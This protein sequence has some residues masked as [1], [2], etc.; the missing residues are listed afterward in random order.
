MY[1][2]SGV[3]MT[4]RKYEGTELDLF[5]KAL[6]WK[7]YYA[8]RISSCIQGDVLEVGAGIGGITVLL[9]PGQA[10]SWLCVEPDSALA[11]T[12]LKTVSS[13]KRGPAPKVVVGCLEDVEADSRFDCILYI[14]VLEHIEADRA[15]MERAAALLR[16]GGRIVV[17]SPAHSFLYSEF[18]SQIGH[19]RR[20][21]RN[22]IAAACPSGVTVESCFYLDS[23]G[24]L[25]S[26]ANKLMLRSA[27]PTEAQILI[28]DRFVIPAS[29]LVDRLLGYRFGKSI[30]MVWRKP[31]STRAAS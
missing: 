27:F 28:W 19:F 29:R 20:Y 30:V 1:R 8:S 12:L 3:R 15:E 18:D 7:R 22:S 21:N 16:A 17:L 6:N 5:A 14:D 31:E 24:I 11:A 23:V 2:L 9:W 10:T 26:L 25:V 13:L 4:D